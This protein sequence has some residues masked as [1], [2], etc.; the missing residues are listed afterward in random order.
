MPKR[1]PLLAGA[2]CALLLV[3]AAIRAQYGTAPSGYYPASFNGST[4]KGSVTAISNDEVTLSFSKG[5]DTE[6]FTAH[7]E[8]GCSIPG[9]AGKPARIMLPGNIPV[10]SGLTAFYFTGTDKSDAKKGKENWIAAI[11]IDAWG[12]RKIPEDRQGI[13]YCTNSKLLNFQAFR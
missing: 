10:G 13:M 3:S 9:E 6:T 5:A 7:F 8:T 11:S 2:A 4:F 12:K 1:Q